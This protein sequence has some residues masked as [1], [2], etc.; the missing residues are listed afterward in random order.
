M[1]VNVRKWSAGTQALTPS[2]PAS[3]SP[4]RSRSGAR[5]SRER[6]GSSPAAGF[7]RKLKPEFDRAANPAGAAQGGGDSMA[8]KK[9]QL[10][11]D[12]AKAADPQK[13]KTGDSGQSP[14]ARPTFTK[15]DLQRAFERA[16]DPAR[17]S[18]T[19]QQEHTEEFDPDKA[20]QAREKKDELEK[21]QREHDKAAKIADQTATPATGSAEAPGAPSSRPA[22]PHARRPRP[23]DIFQRGEGVSPLRRS[24]LRADQTLRDRAEQR[25]QFAFTPFLQLVV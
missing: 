4:W 25:G 1:A 15:G 13:Q 7:F 19:G 8:A 23:A 2:K 6:E 17:K 11:R 22:F 12:F 21:R 14:K 16:K 20:E 10:M 24:P 5:N 3:A 18:D 9:A